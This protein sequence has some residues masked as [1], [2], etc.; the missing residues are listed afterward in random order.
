MFNVRIAA[1]FLSGLFE[2]DAEFDDSPNPGRDRGY[3]TA[4][5][6][7]PAANPC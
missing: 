7:Y 1:L 2:F 4:D 5:R 6:S 3:S